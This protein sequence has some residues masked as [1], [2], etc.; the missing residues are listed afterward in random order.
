MKYKVGDKIV[1]LEGREVDCGIDYDRA[2]VEKKL[3]GLKPA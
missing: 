1:P 3:K 2:E